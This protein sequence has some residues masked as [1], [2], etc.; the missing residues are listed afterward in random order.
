MR[1]ANYPEKNKRDYSWDEIAFFVPREFYDPDY[2]FRCQR[3][4][5]MELVYQMDVLRYNSGCR[6]VTHWGIGGALDMKGTH[7]HAPKSYHRH[8][9][10]GS[11][12]DF[13]FER[14]KNNVML[15]P[16]QQAAVVLQAGFGGVGI[17]Y[18]W[19]WNG[20]MLDIGFH[21]DLRPITQIW[22]RENGEYLYLLK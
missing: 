4:I 2:G 9:M 15:T 10:G 11:A 20:K 18:D 19:M 13:H 21:V 1:T 6:I 14:D 22:R 12:V 17:Y 16:R 8:D 3:Y 7:G 5:N